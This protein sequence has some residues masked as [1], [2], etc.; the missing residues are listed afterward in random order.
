MILMSKFDKHQY[1]IGPPEPSRRFLRARDI[2]RQQIQDQ[3][4]RYNKRTVSSSYDG[5]KWIK[6]E[7]MSL[8]A[9]H[10]S[11]AYKGSVFS[12]FVEVS[13]EVSTSFEQKEKYR[14]LG[15]CHK[16]N[17]IPCLFKI[18]VR[19]KQS[20]SLSHLN[21]VEMV[22]FTLGW[23]LYHAETNERLNPEFIASDDLTPMSE[24]ELLN[25]AIQIVRSD[26]E[27]Q[28]YRLLSYCDIPDVNHQIWIEDDKGNV[29][30]V[31]VKYASG[32]DFDF[33]NWI[34]L[35][36]NA[37][38]LKQFDGFF[39]GVDFWSHRSDSPSDLCRG[40]QMSV[41][42]MGLQRVYVA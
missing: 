29:S 27:K 20:Y 30:W 31:F 9:D 40:D 8:S 5:F 12:V 18:E 16:N 37:E 34:G 28:G 3:F 25:F 1:N 42:Y 10:L 39:A 2:A 36:K 21:D 23:N 24:W 32:D 41:K 15:F 22:P 33:H 38:Q 11:F 4:S 6:A 19:E 13:D 14:L 17:L 35:E 7:F 26:V